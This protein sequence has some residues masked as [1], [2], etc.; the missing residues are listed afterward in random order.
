MWP[1]NVVFEKGLSSRY[2][3]LKYEDTHQLYLQAEIKSI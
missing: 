1:E 2:V 3:K